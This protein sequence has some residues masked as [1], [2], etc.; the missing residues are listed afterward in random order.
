MQFKGYCVF[1]QKIIKNKTVKVP[2]KDESLKRKRLS[3]I[4]FDLSQP[5]WFDGEFLQ[6]AR[7]RLSEMFREIT[8][9]IYPKGVEKPVAKWSFMSNI[10]SIQKKQVE[11]SL[12]DIHLRIKNQAWSLIK[13]SRFGNKYV[14]SFSH[15]QTSNCR[16][17]LSRC[18]PDS[19]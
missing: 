6:T 9:C 17:R 12:K 3:E 4:I 1:C 13:M 8:V 14:Q 16:T 2:L 11:P 18:C 7:R 5:Y 19:I 15:L 10:P